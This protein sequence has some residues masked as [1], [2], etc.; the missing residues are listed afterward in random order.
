MA[1]ISWEIKLA[2]R[3]ALISV[4]GGTVS[5][6]LRFY[7]LGW[8]GDAFSF[9]LLGFLILL[10]AL[11]MAR[12]HYS[13]IVPALVSNMLLIGLWVS[14]TGPEPR[15]GP[16]LVMHAGVTI[17][18]A[19]YRLRG[20]ALAIAT[21]T[22]GL[23][24]IAWRLSLQEGPVVT[25]LPPGTS[26][27]L[28]W[29]SVSVGFVTVGFLVAAL[30][31]YVVN[32][33]ERA[34]YHTQLLLN[35]ARE[36]QRVLEEK[37]R[38]LKLFTEL[39]SDY[40]Y[41]VSLKKPNLVPQIFAGSFERITGYALDELE[42][43]GGWMAIVYPDDREGLERQMPLLLDGQSIV[44]EYRIVSAGG[45]IVWLRDHVRPIRDEATGAVVELIGAVHDV[46]ERRLA[47]EQV[48]NLAFY[49]PLTAL[50]NRRLLLDR[51]EQALAL[52]AR[53]GFRGALLFID[54]DHFKNLNDSKGHEAGDELL[55]QQAR[56]LKICVR[57]GDTVARL[58]GDEFIIILGELSEDAEKAA[59]DLK[60]K[61]KKEFVIE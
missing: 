38:L 32:R 28:H 50:P 55:I 26:L 46:T 7:R 21:G 20:A 19:Y 8:R 44:S 41:Q 9:Y 43:K 12:A 45:K 27:L 31:S 29:I 40:V 53:T 16:F 42:L 6:L 33:M 11:L 18:A 1:I 60:K 48:E 57:E 23:I 51:L 25:S 47:E 14:A 52:S 2:R 17:A 54:L 13:L 4:A 15:P 59:R 58:G 34:L 24:V 35:E 36:R 22:A 3:L 37:E 61:Y 39:S 30:V 5:C 49:D 10:G 56:R